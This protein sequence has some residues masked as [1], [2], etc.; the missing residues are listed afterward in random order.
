MGMIIIRRIVSLCLM[1]GAVLALVGVFMGAGNIFTPLT[2]SFAPF[3]F[4]EFGTALNGL[5]TGALG[6]PFMLFILGFI[7]LTMPTPAKKL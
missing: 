2:E 3:N 1:I 7:G 6:M 4:Q 5:I